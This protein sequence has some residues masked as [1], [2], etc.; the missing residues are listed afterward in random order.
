MPH[1]SV[2]PSLSVAA[3]TELLTSYNTAADPE[4][5]T[6]YQMVLLAAD[7]HL[8]PRQIAPLVQRSHDVVLRVLHRY[9]DGGLAAVPR[10]TG[11]GPAPKVTATW[12]N[13]LLRVIED[14]PHQH[15]VHSANWTTQLLADYLNAHTGIATNQETVRR[16]LHRHAY[17]C[18]RPTWTVAHKAAE[19]EDW[20][21]KGCGVR[22]S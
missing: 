13:E 17:V 5:R 6:R 10:R 21:G 9:R 11:P 7:Q 15:G 18:K 20:V 14:D 19:R 3:H 2:L 8:S 1:Q 12:Q 16:Y 4:S 22:S